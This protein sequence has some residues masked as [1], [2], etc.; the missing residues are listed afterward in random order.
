MTVKKM[1]PG[2]EQLQVLFNFIYSQGKAAG[3]EE[4][5]AEIRMALGFEDTK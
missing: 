1:A 4:R 3:S 5:A 2:L